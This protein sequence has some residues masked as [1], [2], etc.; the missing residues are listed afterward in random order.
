MREY[1]HEHYGSI[2]NFVAKTEI[3]LS[4]TYIYKLCDDET[5]NPTVAVLE[6]LS[7]VLK[8]PIEEVMKLVYSNRH[9]D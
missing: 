8:I 4:R 6:E 5:V 1:I 9:R 3:E 2:D 7:R